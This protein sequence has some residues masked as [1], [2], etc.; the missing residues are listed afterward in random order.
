MKFFLCLN[1]FIT[2]CIKYI[3]TWNGLS[4]N[5]TSAHDDPHVFCVATILFLYKVDRQGLS[6]IALYRIEAEWLFNCYYQHSV[7]YTYLYLYNKG[8]IYAHDNRIMI[9]DT[10][11]AHE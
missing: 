2:H 7:T 5:I 9:G 1:H 8:L 4:I 3:R 11:F 10:I 6:L